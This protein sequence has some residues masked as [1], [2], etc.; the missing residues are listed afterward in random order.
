MK[1]KYLLLLL[2]PVFS[3]AS[4]EQTSEGTDI[5]AR[6]V[7]FLIFAGILYYLIADKITAFFKTRTA[8]I[9][10]RLTSIQDMLNASKEKKEDAL[11]EAAQAKE[12]AKELIEVA[13]KEALLLT[14]K[15][16]ED[17]ESEILYLKKALNERMEIEE[18]KMTK[19]VVSEVIDEMFKED[20]ISLSN[21]DFLNIIKK[22]VA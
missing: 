1:K 13:K 7:N 9:A 6:T 5:V 16:E 3:F 12:K 17:T 10:N 8:D 18:K 21:E 2:L 4:G 11:N 20:K 15:V 14:K 22:K 19:E